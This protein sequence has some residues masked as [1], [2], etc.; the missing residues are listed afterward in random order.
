MKTQLFPLLVATLSLFV[1]SLARAQL[2]NDPFNGSSVTVN[3]GIGA[4]NPPSA[5]TTAFAT[6]GATQSGGGGAI[7]APSGNFGISYLSSLTGTSGSTY[8]LT[9]VPTDFQFTINSV[10]VSANNSGGIVEYIG[11]PST[12]AG[13]K[14]ELGVVS[15]NTVA[16]ADNDLYDNTKGGLYVGLF[17]NAAGQLQGNLRAV[18]SSHAAL[19][20]NGVGTSTLALFSLASPGNSS[21]LT[22]Q[23]DLTSTGYTVLFSEAATVTSGSLTGTYGTAVTGF[24]AGV[25]LNALGQNVANGRGSSVLGD[26]EV[27]AVPEPSSLAMLA[28]GAAMLFTL[29]RQRCRKSAGCGQN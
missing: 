10:S 19:N 6:G 9:S 15:G 18:N 17:Y 12:N 27:A 26:V 23:F 13:V 16:G 14:I 22:V 21:P 25:R 2:F 7:F 20:D 3:D 8:G 5:S 11:G 28:C 1:G 24:G 29:N 4:V